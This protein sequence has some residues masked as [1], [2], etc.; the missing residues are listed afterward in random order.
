V[1][2]HL[3]GT[4]EIK[5]SSESPEPKSDKAK[6][7]IDD[8]KQATQAESPLGLNRHDLKE[9]H[10]KIYY[11]ET[12]YSYERIFGD[13]LK[14]AKTISV[15]D[16]FIRMTHQIQ[17][18][19]RFCE[20]AI[21]VGD[22]KKIKLVTG[23][24]QDSQK[25]EIEEKLQMLRLSLIEQDVEFEFKFSKTIHDREVALDNGWAIKIGRGF[26]IYQPPDNWFSVGCSDLGLRPCLE[27]KV[28]I[29]RS[30]G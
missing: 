7:K 16:P 26:D 22:V 20:L 21:R 30:D 2:R 12:G 14:G 29:F 5:T 17:N 9:Q 19:M 10:Y 6:A 28:D 1:R 11:G 3:P 25:A 18:F 24:E 23:Y 15:E 13:Y 4:P 8:S 27:T